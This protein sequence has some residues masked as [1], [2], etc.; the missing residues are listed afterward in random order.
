MNS[1]EI[2]KLLITISQI[3]DKQALRQINDIVYSKLQTIRDNE[4]LQARVNFNVGDEVWFD[5]R[6]RG[7]IYGVIT[8]INPKTI[9]VDAGYCNWKVAPTLLRHRVEPTSV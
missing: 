9:H 5:T 4:N 6:K 2:T 7:R 1:Q 3:D 8:K